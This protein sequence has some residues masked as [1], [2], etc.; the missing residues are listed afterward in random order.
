[1]LVNLNDYVSAINQAL[2]AAIQANLD[3]MKKEPS[4][5]VIKEYS[6]LIG[7]N[8]WFNLLINNENKSQ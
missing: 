6:D 5:E 4:E 2:D 3:A 8:T 7:A 1:M